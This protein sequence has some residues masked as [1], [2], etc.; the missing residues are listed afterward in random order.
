MT[1][2]FSNRPLNGC[3]FEST[4]SSAPA[5][6]T[7]LGSVPKK[8]DLRQMCS[9]VEDQGMTNSC[10]AN[11]VVGALEYHQRKAGRSVTDMSRMF[12]YFNSRKMSNTEN[13]DTGSFI[14][15][16]MAAVLAF[17]AC[18]ERL[19]PFDPAMTTMQP[20]TLAYQ[21]GM[22][23]EAVQY[24]RTELG[25][26]AMAALA[27]GLP[28]VFGTFIPKEYYDQARQTGI[29]PVDNRSAQRPGGGHA[30]LMVGY[31]IPAKV[32]IVR[33][34]WGQNWAEGGYFKLPFETMTSYSDPS[35]FWTIGAIEQ[36]QGFGLSGPTMEDMKQSTEALV[37]SMRKE[38]R[39]D[40]SSEIEDA[41]KGIRSRLRDN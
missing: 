37:A 13:Q 10:T 24:A 19:W 20:S 17:G 36:A 34:S 27:V 15:H 11:A 40:L 2:D 6:V 39:D 29:M 16:A 33:N 4:P 30:M 14:H 26:P 5:L 21:N 18:E 9:P 7:P 31:D 41:K 1:D 22:H 3:L 28:V 12:V 32:W 8:V 25:N 35:H 38:L 23:H